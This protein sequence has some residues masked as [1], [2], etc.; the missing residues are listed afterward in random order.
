MTLL[1]CKVFL[2]L[3]I[4]ILNDPTLSETIREKEQ[5]EEEAS[6]GKKYSFLL[7]KEKSG[8]KIR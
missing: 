7:E 3:R 4:L 5:G 6:C 8:S 2:V 1:L